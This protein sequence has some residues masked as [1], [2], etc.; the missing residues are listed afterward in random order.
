MRNSST[1]TAIWWWNLDK[2]LPDRLDKVIGGVGVGV[3][4]FDVVGVD[5]VN[6]VDA[7][8]LLVVLNLLSPCLGVVGLDGVDVV[9][10]GVLFLAP[11]FTHYDGLLPAYFNICLQS[12]SL[13]FCIDHNTK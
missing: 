12:F 11:Y 10:E 9:F 3:G 4:S 13:L 2:A 1:I 6:Y 5:G 7:E 8:G